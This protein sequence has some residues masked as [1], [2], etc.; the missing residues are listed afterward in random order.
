MEPIKKI[1]TVRQGGYTYNTIKRRRKGN[2]RTL[3]QESIHNIRSL[4]IIGWILQR[5]DN[6]NSPNKSV[7]GR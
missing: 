4:N 7:L 1:A 6:N 5:T 3:P 2:I